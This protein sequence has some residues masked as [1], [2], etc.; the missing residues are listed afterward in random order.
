VNGAFA[1]WS[2]GRA[3]RAAAASASVTIETHCQYTHAIYVGT[4][5]DTTCG[6]VTATLDGGAPVTL[7]C[8]YPA[9][10]TSGWEV[11]VRRSISKPA[12]THK[13]A[14]RR[15][16]WFS[17]RIGVSPRLARS[18]SCWYG[19]WIAGPAV[20]DPLVTRQ[21][22]KRLGDGCVVKRGTGSDQ[23]GGLGNL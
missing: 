6:I 12:R 10:T 3:I 17:Y 9:A 16:P 18:I 11:F 23:S 20:T 5:L 13:R 8:Y 22:L 1:F 2:Q 15:Q 4:R 21:Q 19:G 7:D 14:D